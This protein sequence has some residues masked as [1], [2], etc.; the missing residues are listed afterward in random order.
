MF[1]FITNSSTILSIF[2]VDTINDT[3]D[4]SGYKLKLKFEVMPVAYE[5]SLLITP[6]SSSPIHQLLAFS[7]ASPGSRFDTWY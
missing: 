6:S 1:N 5:D 7:P 2:L 3:E 4:F